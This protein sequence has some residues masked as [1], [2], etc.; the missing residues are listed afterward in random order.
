[1]SIVD[2]DG[3][4]EQDRELNELSAVHVVAV[5]VG[6]VALNLRLQTRVPPIEEVRSVVR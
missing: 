2:V 1:M 3:V 5:K 4:F 6:E